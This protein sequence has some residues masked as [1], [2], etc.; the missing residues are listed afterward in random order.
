MK[1]R[2]VGQCLL[3]KTDLLPAASNQLAEL[4]LQGIHV[5]SGKK[6]ERGRKPDFTLAFHRQNDGS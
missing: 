3:A 4:L 1:S 2:L 5:Q 6:G